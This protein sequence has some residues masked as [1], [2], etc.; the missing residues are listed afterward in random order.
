VPE[1][2]D[3]TIYVEALEAQFVGHTLNRVRLASPFVL[4]THEPPLSSVFG[5][6]LREV[7]RLGKR[8]VLGF[9]AELYLVLHLMI[10]GRLRAKP[11]GAPIPNKVGLLAFDFSGQTLLLTEAS[12]K[13]RASL[14]VVQGRE[15]LTAMDPG[16][17]EPFAI[18]VT[19]FGER[20]RAENHTLKRS[21]TDPHLFAAIG[22]A[23]SDEIL[24]RARLSPVLLTSRI[25]DTQ[26][27]RLYQ[28]THEVLREW[29]DRLRAEAAGRF[30][31]KVT[32]FHEAM[33][34]HGRYGK[35]CPVCGARVQRIRRSANEANYCPHCQTEGK[36]L[37]DRS[38][39]RLLHD[40]W[41]ASAEELDEQKRVRR[42]N[43]VSDS[44]LTASKPRRKPRP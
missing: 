1:Y 30:P 21:L 32:A 22:N 26:I 20:L 42:E 16:G 28:A 8:L 11:L 2:P 25:D 38:L 5:Q 4:R 9:D 7:R 29:T 3:L 33:A 43:S 19:G 14:H 44:A 12:P 34:V 37:A 40:D 41:P 18:S 31:D 6:T 17:L 27:A 39:S 23:Y 36:L 24:H 13:K 10:A 35:P 15:A